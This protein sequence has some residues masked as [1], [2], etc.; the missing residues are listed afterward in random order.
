M[1]RVMELE[2]IS[3]IISCGGM[4]NMTLSMLVAAVFKIL[5]DFGAASTAFNT[6]GV[7][8]VLYGLWVL[9]GS[10][11]VAN[12]IDKIADERRKAI[13]R[14]RLIKQRQLNK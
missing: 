4:V 13:R 9:V 11:V 3:Y 2:E 8:V 14:K 12:K 5:V 7:V 1:K 6:A 10:I